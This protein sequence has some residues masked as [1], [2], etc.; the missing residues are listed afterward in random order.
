MAGLQSFLPTFLIGFHKVES[1]A[2]YVAYVSRIRE[3]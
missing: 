3:T 2:D 1:E